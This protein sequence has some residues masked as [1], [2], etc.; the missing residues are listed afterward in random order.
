MPRQPR[1]TLPGVAMHVVQRGNDRAACFRSAADCQ[2][3]LRSL[4]ELGE[5]R[6]CAVH[7]YC[8]M[9]NHVHLLLT[10]A[11]IDGCA[12]LMRDLGQRY[13]QYF[14]RVHGRTGTLW[15]G[16]FRSCVA[17]SARYVLA[18][19]RYIELNPVRA[20]IVVH[21]RDYAWS[22]HRANA[23]GRHDPIVTAHPEYQA[24][25]NDPSARLDAYRSLF[26]G[27]CD[28]ALDERIRDATRGGFALLS[29]ELK[30]RVIPPPGR[31]L[32]R[33]RRGRRRNAQ[34][35]CA[36]NPQEQHSAK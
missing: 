1:L 35:S 13:V 32:E 8:L 3:Y 2:A 33:A 9:T 12:T 18:C 31:R 26:D 36:G 23:E 6:A 24:L 27:Q 17:E 4:Y 22:S 29:Q 21:P 15:E 7:A 11:A 10:P 30:T 16:R 5:K 14:N 34:A 19:Y 28:A 20:G 25:G